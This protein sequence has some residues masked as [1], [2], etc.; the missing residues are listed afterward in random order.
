[1]LEIEKIKIKNALLLAPMEDVT[2]ISF[3]IICK[4]LG[5]DLV[6]TEFINS[7]GLVRGSKMTRK[8]L[9]FA[10]QERPIGIQIYGG[11]IESM[12]GAAKISET[13]N[14]EIIDINAGCWVKNVVGSGAGA[15]LLKA[16]EH[17]QSLVETVVKSVNKPVTVKTRLG[18][19]ETSINILEVA[20]R[21]EDVGIKALTVH[22][23]T[24]AQGHKGDADW[25]W[26][27]EIKKVIS[28]PVILNGGVMTAEDAIR[29]FSETGADAV[30]IAR[31]AI[32]N[33]WIF[34]EIKELFEF[35]EIKI[36]IDEEMKILTCIKHL[37]L[38][39]ELKGEKRGVVEHRKFYSGYL[40][41]FRNASAA[42]N[43]IMSIFELNPL[44][45]YLLSY[46]AELK[47]EKKPS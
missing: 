39:I 36:K 31:G 19:D 14:P 27:P 10:D 15:G 34:T 17:L 25:K 18:W 37:K 24:R 8:K 43:K 22:C 45:E 23:R 4:Q 6:Y 1:M 30:M 32:D 21:L 29:A 20:K 5:A 38:A 40:K 16:P 41:G 26:I 7:E 33:P 3:R 44:E 13:Y 2:D 47:E 11:K 46:L 35:G 28:I 12:V 42:R 9:E